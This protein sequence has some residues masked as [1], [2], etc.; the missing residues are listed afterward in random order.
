MVYFIGIKLPLFLVDGD[1]TGFCAGNCE[2]D[3]VLVVVDNFGI[4]HHFLIFT[5][6]IQIDFGRNEHQFDLVGCTQHVIEAEID[7][8]V[9]TG[10]LHLITLISVFRHRTGD[11]QHNGLSAGG[12]KGVTVCIQR[13]TLAVVVGFCQIDRGTIGI[14]RIARTQGVN[15]GSSSGTEVNFLYPNVRGIEVIVLQFKHITI[16]SSIRGKTGQGGVEIYILLRGSLRGRVVEGGSRGG[17]QRVG[18]LH[19]MNECSGVHALIT[20]D[21]IGGEEQVADDVQ[22][23]IALTERICQ[24]HALVVIGSGIETIVLREVGSIPII[25]VTRAVIEDFADFLQRFLPCRIARNECHVSGV[26]VADLRIRSIQQRVAMLVNR[27]D[28]N[29]LT[30]FVHRAG[31]R[32][33]LIELTDVDGRILNVRVDVAELCI[34]AQVII[35]VVRERR[36]AFEQV[37]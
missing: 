7:R 19:M 30:V 17:D 10:A 11:T 9:L 33:L 28:V 15:G 4:E 34:V 13:S 27:I 14:G 23:H 3:V 35:D 36:C 18:I 31:H 2:G 22:T 29:H 6:V 16:G 5:A 12:A 26:L 1:A 24:R 25:T 8:H 21:A 37:E 20:L 32:C